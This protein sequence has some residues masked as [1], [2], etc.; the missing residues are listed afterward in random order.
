MVNANM[1]KSKMVLHG[2]NMS[3]LADY[4]GISR[5]TLTLKVSGVNDFNQSEIK[6]II[7]KYNLTPEDTEAIFFGE[8]NES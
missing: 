2:D 1:L 3:M 5:Q 6:M 4:L 7:M 8:D